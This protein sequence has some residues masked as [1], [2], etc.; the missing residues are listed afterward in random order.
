M[1]KEIP[2]KFNNGFEFS[3]RF[4]MDVWAELESEICLIGDIGEKMG[5]GK[6]RLKTTVEIAAI[7]T[8]DAKIAAA[9]IWGNMEPPDHAHLIEAITRCVGANLAMETETEEENAVHDVV[10]E[11]IE[12]KK[13]PAG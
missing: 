3:L 8:G 2:V 1:L 5:Q 13:E 11:E 4:T 9:T 10:L 7:M 6:E 12:A